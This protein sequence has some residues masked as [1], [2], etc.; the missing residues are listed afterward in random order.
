MNTFTPT[1]DHEQ[2]NGVS[3]SYL[4][5]YETLR[6]LRNDFG[7]DITLYNFAQSYCMYAFNIKPSYGTSYAP[8]HGHVR[9]SLNFK[10]ALK[11]P[12]VLMI[13]AET[14]AL[15]EITNTRNVTV[16]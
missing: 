6:E 9:L 8:D 1:F 3:A 2:G 16:K 5:L 13:H 4:C 7:N 12:V 14:P 11:E 10:K 15:M